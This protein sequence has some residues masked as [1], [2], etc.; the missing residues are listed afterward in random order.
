MSQKNKN[1]TTHR[2]PGSRRA[3]VTGCR[4]PIFRWHARLG[5]PKKL[6][7]LDSHRQT[8]ET[9]AAYEQFVT[10]ISA[11]FHC[12]EHPLRLPIV[13]ASLTYCQC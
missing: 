7:K 11:R 4:M 6:C 10:T 9:A 1:V 12:I 13:I 8:V 2:H 5:N 3:S